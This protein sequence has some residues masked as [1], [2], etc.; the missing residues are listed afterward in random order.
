MVKGIRKMVFFAGRRVGINWEEVG[1]DR[2]FLYF[3]GGV[4]YMV[5][6]FC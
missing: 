1:S 2:N 5:V 3:D 6:C 4:G